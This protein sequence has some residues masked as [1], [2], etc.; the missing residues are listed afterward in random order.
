MKE[1]M[2]QNSQLSTTDHTRKCPIRTLKYSVSESI[3]LSVLPNKLQLNFISI[4]DKASN[5][6]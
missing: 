5:I 6:S 4:S 3:M 2:N 1:S